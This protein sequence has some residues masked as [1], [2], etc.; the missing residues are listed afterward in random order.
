[1]YVFVC[2]NDQQLV[3][4]EC[5]D[6]GLVGLNCEKNISILFVYCEICKIVNEI[7]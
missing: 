7:T 1:M 2:V 3:K 4:Y 6:E 5:I